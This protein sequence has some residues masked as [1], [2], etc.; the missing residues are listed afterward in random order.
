[1]PAERADGSPVEFAEAVA[2]WGTAARAILEDVAR[3]RSIITYGELA[4]EV[5]AVTA[6]RTGAP[7]RRWIGRVLRALPPPT[8]DEEPELASLVV[9]ADGHIGSGYTGGDDAAAAERLRVYRWWSGSF[10]PR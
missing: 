8:T 1:M 3:Q 5:Q 7:F 6:V 4:E 2:L 10:G 9:R